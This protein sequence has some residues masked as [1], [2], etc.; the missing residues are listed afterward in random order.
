VAST[1][2]WQGKIET[3]TEWRCTIKSRASLYPQLEAAIRQAHSYHTPEI[4]CSPVT[5]GNPDY[6]AWLDS[7]LRRDS[8]AS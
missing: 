8:P 5:A 2:W 3:T 4:L 6:F 7:E 1:Y